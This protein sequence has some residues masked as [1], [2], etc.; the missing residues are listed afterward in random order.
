MEQGKHAE[1]MKLGGVYHSLVQ[2]QEEGNVELEEKDKAEAEQDNDNNT[3]I[4]GGPTTPQDDLTRASFMKA[5]EGIRR[6]SEATK[7]SK[8]EAKSTR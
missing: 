1:L 6:L 5:S 2:T 8:F 4:E 3:F 7:S